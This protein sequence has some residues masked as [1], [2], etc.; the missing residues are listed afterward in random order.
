ML[1]LKVSCTLMVFKS[2]GLLAV[3]ALEIKYLVLSANSLFSFNVLGGGGGGG[4]GVC[5]C[6]VVVVV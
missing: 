4:G 2:L 6:V 3:S 5:M 1:R